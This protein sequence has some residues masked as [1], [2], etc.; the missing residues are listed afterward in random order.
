MVDVGPPMQVPVPVRAAGICWYLERLS[1]LPCSGGRL[2][3]GLGSN[4]VSKIF[5]FQK[6]RRSDDRVMTADK[7]LQN[8]WKHESRMHTHNFGIGARDEIL[9]VNPDSL[10]EQATYIGDSA[11]ITTTTAA[12]SSSSFVQAQ[13][14]SF[15]NAMAEA[16]G[17]DGRQQYP[18]LLHMNCE[19]CEWDLLPQGMVAGFIQQIPILQIGF[20][21]YGHEHGL[22]GRV[23]QLCEIRQ[24][25]SQTHTLEEKGGAAV[26]FAW[27]RWVLT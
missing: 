22:G 21:N 4:Q 17:G 1:L 8:N 25:L 19:G 9:H 20:H 11:A 12:A 18:T 15:A 24:R 27:E 7:V 14:K 26:P 3:F 23:W 10:Q 6:T 5:E 13:I 16:A 2:V